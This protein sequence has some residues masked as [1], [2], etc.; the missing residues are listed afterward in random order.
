MSQLFYG[1]ENL[2]IDVSV[3]IQEISAPKLEFDNAFFH[4]GIGR[5]TH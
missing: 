5:T 1:G 3:K 4:R 2:A